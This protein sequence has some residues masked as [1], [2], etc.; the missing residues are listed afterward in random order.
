MLAAV[1]RGCGVRHHFLSSHHPLSSRHDL[2]AA[3]WG[4]GD[5][6]WTQHSETQHG[7]PSPTH[8]CMNMI[9]TWTRSL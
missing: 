5:R 3:A 2:S 8:M 1:A 7:E 9:R 6:A 4:V